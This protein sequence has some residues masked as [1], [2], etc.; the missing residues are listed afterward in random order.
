MLSKDQFLEWLGKLQDAEE[1]LNDGMKERLEDAI[2][3]FKKTQG[4]LKRVIAEA[5]ALED[6]FEG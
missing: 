4:L 6:E 2:D 3:S 5:E 1:A